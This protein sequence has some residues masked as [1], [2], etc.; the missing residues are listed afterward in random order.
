MPPARQWRSYPQTYRLEAARCKG[1][2]KVFFPPRLVCSSCKGRDFEAFRMKRTGKVITH[3]VI[4]TPS[5]DFAGLAPFA[6]GI[7]E[8]D[9]GVRLTSQIV[10][11]D[12][13]EVK[14][15][16]P[17]QM[18]FRRISAEGDA[19]AISYGYKAVPVRQ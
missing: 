9:D 19:G 11:A 13:E 17:V 3:T 14:I 6:V 10:D 15:G 5:D 12:L 4:R 1:C 18:E 8:M 16:M 7:I 2:G